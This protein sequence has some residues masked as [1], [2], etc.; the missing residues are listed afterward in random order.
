MQKLI[1]E[2]SN[3]IKKFNAFFSVINANQLMWVISIK[4]W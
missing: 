3:C 2:T 1:N 4:T